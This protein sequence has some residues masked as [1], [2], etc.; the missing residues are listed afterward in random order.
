MFARWTDADVERMQL[1]VPDSVDIGDIH[2]GREAALKE[3]DLESAVYTMSQEKRD[4]LKR[5]LENLEV[6]PPTAAD[7]FTAPVTVSTDG[8]IGEV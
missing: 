7:A 4:E 8:K 6:E 1:L 2:Y 5:T 3:R